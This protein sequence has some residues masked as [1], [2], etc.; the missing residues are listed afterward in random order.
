MIFDTYE[1]ASA[2]ADRRFCCT[3][4]MPG[5]PHMMT[6]TFGATAEEAEGKAGDWIAAHPV[7]KRA[8]RPEKKTTPATPPAATAAEIE[9]AI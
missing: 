2:P 1:S 7:K 6:F 8:P 5:N 4:R 3:I 9:E